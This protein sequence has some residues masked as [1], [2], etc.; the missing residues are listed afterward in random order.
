MKRQFQAPVSMLQ[1]HT[2][3]H[4]GRGYGILTPLRALKCN[5]SLH[6]TG[7]AKNHHLPS[8][9]PKVRTFQTT[10]LGGYGVYD[11][12]YH[13]NFQIFKRVNGITT[14]L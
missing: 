3:P 8:N 10:T 4:W 12:E 13:L 7:T 6:P 1:F 9:S 11:F 14:Q 2:M 5:Q